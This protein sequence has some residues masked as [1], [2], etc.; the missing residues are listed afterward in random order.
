[1]QLRVNDKVL[2][3]DGE[4]YLLNPDDWDEAVAQAMAAELDLDEDR[5]EVVRYVR[6]HYEDNQSVPELRTV[7]KVLRERYGGEKATRKYIYRLFPYGYGQQACKIAGM[8]KP[9]K[10]MLDI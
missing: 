7:L 8:R 9:L 5:W 4:G 10:L 2:D 3:T 1:M 6:Q